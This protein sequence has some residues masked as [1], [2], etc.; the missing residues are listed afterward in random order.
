MCIYHVT[1]LQLK[2]GPQK[3]LAL[4]QLETLLQKLFVSKTMRLD[5]LWC[6]SLFVCKTKWNFKPKGEVITLGYSDNEVG[7][8][9]Y[10]FTLGCKFQVWQLEIIGNQHD[11]IHIHTLQKIVDAHCLMGKCYYIIIDSTEKLY[12]IQMFISGSRDGGR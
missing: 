4:G 8:S 10:Q 9:R 2:V 3:L 5:S 11:H 1:Y 7:T 6:P 12:D